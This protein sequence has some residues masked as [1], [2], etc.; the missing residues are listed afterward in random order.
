MTIPLVIL[1]VGAAVAGVAFYEFFIGHHY[2]EFWKGTLGGG[3][4]PEIIE[5]MHHVPLWVK[6]SPFVMMVLGY[7]YVRALTK[8]DEAR[9]GA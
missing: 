4:H 7:F 8:G 5:A 1:A 3:E 9:A 6:L 2:A